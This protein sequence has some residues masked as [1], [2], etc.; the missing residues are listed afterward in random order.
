[1]SSNNPEFN[2]FTGVFVPTFLTIIGVIFYLKLGFIVG[3]VGVLGTILIIILAVSVTFSTSLAIISQVTNTEI[4]GGGPYS[5]I[6]KTLGREI[7]GSIGIPLFFAM[8]FSVVFYILGFVRGWLYVFPGHDRLFVLLGVFALLFILTS[9]STRLAV[10]TQTTVFILVILSIITIFFSGGLWFTKSFSTSLIA[11]KAPFWQM[12]ALFFPAVTGIFAGL[13]LA[14]ELKDAR[15][16]LPKGFLSAVLVTST[17]Y[18]LLALWFGFVSDPSESLKPYAL[19]NLSFFP[20]IVLLGLLVATFSSG[21][22][23]LIAAPRLLNALAKDSVIPLHSFFRKVTKKGEP[24]HAILFTNV[25]ILVALLLGTLN[26]IASVLTGLYLITYAT[27]N[28]SVFIQQSLGITSFRPTFRIPKKITSYGALSS[29]IVLLLINLFAGIASILVM[30][31]IFY[32]L[33]TKD[34]GSRKGDV[35]YPLF[36]TISN[37]FA[38]QAPKYETSAKYSWQPHILLP[39]K[40]KKDLKSN[41]A[42]LKPI[43]KPNGQLIALDTKPNKKRT[44]DLIALA[45]WYSHKQIFVSYLAMSSESYQQAI[46]TYLESAKGQSNMPNTIFLPLKKGELYHKIIRIARKN[47]LGVLISNHSNEEVSEGEDVNMWISDKALKSRIDKDRNFDLGALIAYNLTKNLNSDTNIWMKTARRESS[48]QYLDKLTEK[49]RIPGAN[50]FTYK[51]NILDRIN[52]E[53]IN[54]ISVDT[55]DLDLLS[56]VLELKSGRIILA[57]DSGQEDILA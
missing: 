19:M 43:L 34:L 12:F 26:K 1:M 24:H 53:E 2:A 11:T 22:A 17:L 47:G 50:T 36:I 10:K 28:L 54:I 33:S 20:P 55:N 3:S 42:V 51:G 56:R 5:I 57:I 23:T 48:Q 6:S 18:I 21:L 37:W 25:I 15:K 52:K 29:I 38:R 14:G 40:N 31:M 13:G 32:Y 4:S 41:F 9:F 8:S 46:E 35:R 49:A 45:K 27:I 16:Q 44:K 7:G 30:I 39:L